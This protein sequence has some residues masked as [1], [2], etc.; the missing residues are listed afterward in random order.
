M[1][2]GISRLEYKLNKLKSIQEEN[3]QSYENNL[4]FLK[5]MKRWLVYTDLF[6]VQYRVPSL[7]S[8]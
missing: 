4:D 8:F 6:W 2:N 3:R 7:F 5:T 1:K